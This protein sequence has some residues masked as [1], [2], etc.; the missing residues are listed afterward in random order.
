MSGGLG[1]VEITAAAA[2]KIKDILAEEPMGAAFRIGVD[3]GGCS[4]FKYCY[5]VAEQPA[6][7]DHLVEKDGARLVVDE[8]S[9][10]FLLGAKVDFVDDLMGQAFKIEN[11]NAAA[12]C[13]CGVSFSV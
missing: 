13:G 3:G 1:E 11:P 8:T 2:D 12:S 7:G 10:P 5:S 4:G 9:L 6:A